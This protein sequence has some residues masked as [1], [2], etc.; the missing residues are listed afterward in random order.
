MVVYDGMSVCTWVG[1]CVG[2]GGGGD[3]REGGVRG[4][5]N[6]DGLVTTECVCGGGGGAVVGGGGGRA[7]GGGGGGGGRELA[8]L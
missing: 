3:G 8:R 2:G 4:E 6:T 7:V 5:A 1:V